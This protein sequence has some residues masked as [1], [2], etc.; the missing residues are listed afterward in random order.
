MIALALNDSRPI[1]PFARYFGQD[2]AHDLRAGHKTVLFAFQDSDL[3]LAHQLAE[4]AYVVHRNTR[5]FAA[6]MDN[7]RA[8]DVFIAE[9]N[10]L[11]SLKTHHEICSGIRMGGRAVPNCKGKALVECTLMF[12]LG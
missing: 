8:V 4:P 12:A 5:V 2:V 1:F 7:D 10:S 3:A 9:A 6:V 11:L